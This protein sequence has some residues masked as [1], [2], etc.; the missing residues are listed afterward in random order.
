M[1]EESSVYEVS[2]Y[3]D[4]QDE[5]SVL[6]LDQDLVAAAR[7]LSPQEARYLVDTYYQVQDDR[8]TA[9]NRVRAFEDSGEP[10]QMIDWYLKNAMILENQVKKAL[11]IYSGE[12]PIGIWLRSN[13]GIGPVL[14]AGLLAYIDI[15]KADTA[16][17]IWS[18]AGLD[19]DKEWLGEVKSRALVDEVLGKDKKIKDE[20]IIQICM[21]AKINNLQRFYKLK[22][23]KGNYNKREVITELSVRPWNAKLKTLCWK[24]G[25]SFQKV[26]NRD[27]LYGKIYK[28]RRIMEIE[29]NEKL[30]FKDQAE[31]ALATKNYSKDT[32][33]YKAYIVGKLPPAQINERAKRY[34]VKIFLSHLHHVMY[35]H[36]YGVEPPK[37]FAI[38]ILGHAHMI[39]IPNQEFMPKRQKSESD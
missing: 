8:K 38:G 21:R 22:N 29:K 30:M 4:I 6:K 2:N 11:D 20:H 23:D 39:E 16:G 18:Y 9:A 36:H 12:H 10:H 14:S 15:T 35:V 17:A 25:E 28:E 3:L 34:A 37:P 19:P 7:I 27:S 31:R 24:A 1:S 26:S 33:A 13:L 32:E 5:E